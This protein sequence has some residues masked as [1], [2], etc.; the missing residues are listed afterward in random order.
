VSVAILVGN[1]SW[2][3][4]GLFRASTRAQL[5]TA[6]LLCAVFALDYSEHVAIIFVVVA[7]TVCD[8]A[9][10]GKGGATEGMR[11]RNGAIERSDKSVAAKQAG[12][13]HTQAGQHKA[14]VRGQISVTWAFLLIAQY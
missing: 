5:T 8:G 10:I 13:N 12:M 9:R 4:W 2:G 6:E 7:M 14:S 3:C 11:R 1:V